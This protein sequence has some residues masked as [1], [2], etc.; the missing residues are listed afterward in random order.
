MKETVRVTKNLDCLRATTVRKPGTSGGESSDAIKETE[1][2]FHPDSGNVIVNDRGDSLA[3]LLQGFS[4][5]SGPTPI[6][7]EPGLTLGPIE[8]SVEG[9][10]YARLCSETGIDDGDPFGSEVYARFDPPIYFG[11]WGDPHSV[12]DRF[13]N[14]LTIA[15]ASPIGMCRVICSADGFASAL[16]TENVFFTIGDAEILEKNWPPITPLLVGEIALAWKNTQKCWK[17]G[18]SKSRLIRALEYFY[19]AWRSEHM[20]QI[21]L[22]LGIV[23]E[24]LFGPHS[25]PSRKN[26]TWVNTVCFACDL[27]EEVMRVRPLVQRLCRLQ[28]E[29][30]GGLEQD[31]DELDDVVAEAFPFVAKVLNTILLDEKLSLQFNSYPNN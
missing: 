31:Y 28:S 30:A 15:M 21:C 24:E 25:N 19:Y 9:R 14:L 16:Y 12:V 4:W 20:D 5:A 7:I 27:S 26:P 23:L 22:N 1:D 18:M 13:Y 11:D 17:Q 8:N 2:Q 6:D 29:I 10:L 3:A